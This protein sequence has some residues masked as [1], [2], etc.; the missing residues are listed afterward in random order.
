[1]PDTDIMVGEILQMEVFGYRKGLNLT[2]RDI[3]TAGD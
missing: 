1:M 3:V 2:A